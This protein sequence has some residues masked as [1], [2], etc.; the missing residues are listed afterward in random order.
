MSCFRCTEQWFSCVSIHIYTY[1]YI[2]MYI[3][4]F[5]DALPLQPTIK[6]GSLCCML[7]VGHTVFKHEDPDPGCVK[8]GPVHSHCVSRVA[9]LLEQLSRFFYLKCFGCFCFYHWEVQKKKKGLRGRK[10]RFFFFPFICHLFCLNSLKSVHNQRLRWG[11]QMAGLFCLEGTC[12]RLNLC[13]RTQRSD[14]A[15]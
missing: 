1:I 14:L 15:D 13:T 4:F 5:P 7:V 6:C 11:S 10:S 3:N 8:V 9:L 2:Y 12:A